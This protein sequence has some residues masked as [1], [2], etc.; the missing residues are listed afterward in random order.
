VQR[1]RFAKHRIEALSVAQ[2]DP[3]R[4]SRGILLR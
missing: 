2:D 3:W 1:D 4:C